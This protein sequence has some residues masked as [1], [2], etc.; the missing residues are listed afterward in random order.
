MIDLAVAN[1]KQTFRR[2]QA[3]G[4]AR[5]TGTSRPYVSARSRSATR[6]SPDDYDVGLPIPVG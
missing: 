2:M 4:R 1:E 5:Y 6:R 3:A